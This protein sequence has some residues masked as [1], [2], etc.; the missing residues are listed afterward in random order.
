MS[1]RFAQRMHNPCSPTRL[2]DI[3]RSKYVVDLHLL[4]PRLIVNLCVDQTVGASGRA[5]TVSD[6]PTCLLV[7]SP[8]PLACSPE[9]TGLASVLHYCPVNMLLRCVDRHSQVNQHSPHPP[10]RGPLFTTFTTTSPLASSSL[11]KV[12]FHAF[13]S[14][15]AKYLPPPNDDPAF[16]LHQTLCFCCGSD[17]RDTIAIFS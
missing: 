17:F 11:S 6:A 5:E 2:G 7:V 12:N 9:C 13:S 15:P 1:A 4:W 8:L 14:I 16:F 3:R 10:H